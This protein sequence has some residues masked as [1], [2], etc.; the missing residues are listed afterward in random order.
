M[1]HKN[2]E[3]MMT[4]AVDSAPPS[5][6][7]LP[8]ALTHHIACQ[9]AYMKCDRTEVDQCAHCNRMMPKTKPDWRQRKYHRSCMDILFTAEDYRRLM[10]RIKKHRFPD[11]LSITVDQLD[12]VDETTGGITSN[13]L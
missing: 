2:Q 9:Q 6:M 1:A 13:M 11:V 3:K 12:T 5:T 10:R 7:V 4:S 8:L